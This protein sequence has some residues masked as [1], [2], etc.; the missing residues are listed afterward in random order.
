MPA[1]YGFA[2]YVG[3][4]EPS[5]PDHRNRDR[6]LERT[7]VN[8][9]AAPR[10]VRWRRHPVLGYPDAGRRAEILR[11]DPLQAAADLQG[12]PQ[13]QS[14]V[15][16]ILHAQADADHQ[17]PPDRVQDIPQGFT[18]ESESAVQAVAVFVRA[19]VEMGRQ[20]VI[21]P[22]VVAGVDFH[23]VEAG[24]PGPDRSLHE[25]A[26]VFPDIGQ[27]E[28]FGERPTLLKL[29]WIPSRV[30]CRTTDARLDKPGTRSSRSIPNLMTEAAAVGVDEGGAQDDVSDPP[31]ARAA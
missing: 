15:H 25:G 11:A 3:A 31:I 26:T 14:A 6:L 22:I 18:Q 30:C 2:K 21:E 10:N 4:V 17:I 5:D 7:A 13:A 12:L 16:E 23:R 19:A 28:G 29:S 8:Q 24:F 1:L 9:Q 27:V 20:K